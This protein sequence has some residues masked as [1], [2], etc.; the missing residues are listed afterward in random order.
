ML[1]LQR[2]YHISFGHTCSLQKDKKKHVNTLPRKI[3]KQQP[4][5]FNKC[6]YIAGLGAILSGNM[7]K[8]SRGHFFFVSQTL[9]NFFSFFSSIY[10]FLTSVKLYTYVNLVDGFTIFFLS[11]HSPDVLSVITLLFFKTLYIFQNIFYLVQKIHKIVLKKN[12]SC[13]ALISSLLC[14]Y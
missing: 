2:Q 5:Y 1:I 4:M 9:I 6:M 8:I 13:I 12:K 10:L 3:D 7:P 11:A 14:I